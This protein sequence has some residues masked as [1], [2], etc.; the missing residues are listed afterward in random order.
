MSGH[1]KLSYACLMLILQ[2]C[3]SPEQKTDVPYSISIDRSEY[4]VT[5]DT[6]DVTCF[7]VDSAVIL[8][9]KDSM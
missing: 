6:S 2:A 7:D 8:Q 4:S 1:T 5:S 3:S 9:K